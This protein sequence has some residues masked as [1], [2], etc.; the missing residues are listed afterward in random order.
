MTQETID[1]VLL[2]NRHK[3]LAEDTYGDCLRML[4][5]L[6]DEVHIN[7]KDSVD[8]FFERLRQEHSLCTYGNASEFW[9]A[10]HAT[11]VTEWEK[12]CESRKKTL[13]DINKQIEEL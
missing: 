10:V 8:L 5:S 7:K 6:K 9:D 13:D 3:H 1:K 11:I 4:N 12:L 2:Y